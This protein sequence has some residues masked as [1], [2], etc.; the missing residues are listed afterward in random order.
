MCNFTKGEWEVKR[1]VVSGFRVKVKDKKGKQ[2]KIIGDIRT[3]ENANLIAA[4]PEMY[5][6]IERDINELIKLLQGL[7]RYSN[8]Y[9]FYSSEL[10]RKQQL[11]AKAGGENA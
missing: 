6:E 9:L 3:K 11:L 8:D 4:A 10:E 1:T 2:G 7:E 5:D